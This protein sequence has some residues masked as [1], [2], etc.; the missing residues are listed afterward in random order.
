MDNYF[1]IDVVSLS[2]N[3]VSLFVLI[4]IIYGNIFELS[5]GRTKANSYFLLYGI[6]LGVGVL[7][8]AISFVGEIFYWPDLLQKFI[9]T[10]SFTVG[11]IISFL[12][13]LYLLEIIN[14]RSKVNIIYYVISAILCGITVLIDFILS[15]TGNYF[16]VVGGEYTDG[17]Y[18]QVSAN[19]SI[20]FYIWM[21]MLVIRFVKV[22]GLHDFVAFI[23]YILVP[24]FGALV[25]KYL[26]ISIEYAMMV[27]SLLLIFVMIQADAQNRAKQREKVLLDQSLTD[28]MT[29]LYNR[30]AHDRD[31]ESD[32]VIPADFIYLSLDLNGLKST[33]DTY[34]HV[35]GDELIKGVGE[36]LLKT[37]D[38]TGKCYRIGGD[39]FACILDVSVEEMK[40]L[41][42]K[43]DTIVEEWSKAHSRKLSVSYGFATI[44][45]FCH[46][47]NF[48]I[49]LLIK[50]ADGR[51]YKCKANHYEQINV[52][53]R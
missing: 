39:E 47:K 8:D 27:L 43:F 12:F 31:I 35:A 17:A 3:L 2:I 7:S 24:M 10:I 32:R 53:P 19:L 37:F 22:L 16:T 41:L 20:L 33:N 52:L 36:C 30:T 21:F 13:I 9:S 18:T 15:V 29:G 46:V 49:D 14:E 45:E 26:D 48:G 1:L 50:V 5:E 51:M 11:G 4:I 6:I 28:E 23:S 34:G 40:E 38:R 42:E 25:Y 44:K